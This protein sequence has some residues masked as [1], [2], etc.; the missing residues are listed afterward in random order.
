[1]RH[2]EVT[3]EGDWAPNRRDALRVGATSAALNAD[4]GTNLTS[5]LMD[6]DGDGVADITVQATGDHS[7]YHD[8]F[9]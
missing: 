2:L 1:M 7:T 5:F 9:L 8:F 4:A 3:E 6:T